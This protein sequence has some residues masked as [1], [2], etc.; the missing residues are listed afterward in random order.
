MKKIKSRLKFLLGIYLLSQVSFY[1]FSPLYALFGKSLNMT[2]KSIGFIWGTYTLASAFF[3]LVF[4]KFENKKK[5]EGFIKLGMLIYV[6]SD[7]LFLFVHNPE[8]LLL[9]LLLAA[10]GS[11][12][13]FPSI[14]TLFARNENK[15]RESEEWSWMDSGNMLAASIGAFIGGTIISLYSFKGLFIAMAVIQALAFLLSSQAFKKA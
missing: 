2:P 12:V 1:V 11:G 7:L 4:G 10:V 14:K 9:V 5:K 3:I 6:A 15:G 8:S 13:T